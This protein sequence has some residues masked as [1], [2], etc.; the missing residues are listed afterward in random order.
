MF[1][2]LVPFL[3]GTVRISPQTKRHTHVI[4]TGGN[5]T[6]VELG[7]DNYNRPL[8]VKRIPSGSCV[9]KMIKQLITPLLTLRNTNILHYCACDFDNNELIIATPLCEYN[10][11]QYVMLM[12]QN[13]K[14]TLTS[15]DIVRQLLTGIMYLHT[16]TEAI[17]HGNLKPS[18]IFIDSNDVVRVAEFGTHKVS[19]EL[20][21]NYFYKMIFL[22][23]GIV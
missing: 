10:M 2:L 16:Q 15:T 22:L 9:C 11:G 7:L 20:R 1:K 23:T 5:F 19:F 13:N 21:E 18:N 8:A 17:I 14:L 12:K 3:G 4:S 6:P